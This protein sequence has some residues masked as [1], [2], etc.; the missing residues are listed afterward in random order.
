MSEGRPKHRSSVREMRRTCDTTVEPTSAAILRTP[1]QRTRRKRQH[2]PTGSWSPLSNC[3]ISSNF[4]HTFTKGVRVHPACSAALLLRSD[5]LV[6]NR[7]QSTSRP[8]VRG[9]AG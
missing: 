7:K 8:V 3:L 4:P 6:E 1:D 5:E 9:G 2:T